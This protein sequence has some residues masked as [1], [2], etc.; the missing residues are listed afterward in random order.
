M[1][2]MIGT[3]LTRLDC[4][5][6]KVDYPRSVQ[7]ELYEPCTGDIQAILETVKGTRLDVPVQ[8][9]IYGLRRGE[10]CALRYPEDIHD[11]MIHVSGS[12][13]RAVGGKYIVKEPKNSTSDRFVPVDADLINQIHEQGYVTDYTP[14]ALSAAFKRMLAKAGLPDMRFHDLRHFFASYMHYIGMP[15]AQ[16]MRMGGWKTDNV[17][18]RVYRY[19]VNKDELSK[20]AVDKICSLKTK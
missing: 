14:S 7:T 10:I 13:V 12:M 2:G 19:A 9:G 8:L 17:M 16:I 4:K 3:T 15:D 1:T 5:V 11:G 18:K 20:V 6:P